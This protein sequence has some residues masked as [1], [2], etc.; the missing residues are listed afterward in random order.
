M[1]SGQGRIPCDNLRRPQR[2]LVLRLRLPQ[3][4]DPH[5]KV[6]D[7]RLVMTAIS[8]FHF[9][10]AGGDGEDGHPARHRPNRRAPSLAFAE[11]CTVMVA[12]RL[13]MQSHVPAEPTRLS[14]ARA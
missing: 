1:T 5:V 10:L 6:G 9:W 7:D 2:L 3:V 4:F 13:M 11:G 8:A 14:P 12:P